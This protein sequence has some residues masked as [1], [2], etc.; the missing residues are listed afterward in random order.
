ML[1][2]YILTFT[3]IFTFGLSQLG[4]LAHDV[5]HINQNLALLAQTQ[6]ESSN[7]L[8]LQFNVND[9]GQALVNANNL[10]P[11]NPQKTDYHTCEKCV[12]FAGV[13]LAMQQTA[14]SISI[15]VAPEVQIDD[16]KLFS[17][18]CYQLTSLARA[19]PSHHV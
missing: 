1:H 12:G 15:A 9:D 5:S 18:H 16:E 2:R 17:R 7:A 10:S 19:P 4:L 8:V 6:D 11:V 13:A 3:L 14:I